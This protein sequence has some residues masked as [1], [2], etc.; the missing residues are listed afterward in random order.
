MPAKTAQKNAAA[1]LGRKRR[2]H[3]LAIF[4]PFGGYTRP[5]RLG[6]RVPNLKPVALALLVAGV[7]VVDYVSDSVTVTDEG[8]VLL[9]REGITRV[10]AV[11]LITLI[12]VVAA[13]LARWWS[14]RWWV[15]DDMIRTTGGIAHRWKREVAF[16]RIVTVDR[17]TTLWQRIFRVS[18]LA[19]ETTAM[20]QAAP[21]ILLGYLSNRDADLLE[22]LLISKLVFDG[23][24]SEARRFQLIRL[25]RLGWRDLIVAGAMTF[26][27]GRALVALWVT[28]Q[29]LEFL[30][31]PT[32]PIVFDT[33][34]GGYGL[35]PTQLA[36]ALPLGILVILW[37]TST[38]YFVVSFARFRIGKHDAWLTVETG[39]IR[40]VRRLIRIDAIQGLEVSRSPLQRQFRSKRAMLRMRMP[41]YGAPPNYAMVLHPAITD[42]ALPALT[43]QI[44]GMDPATSGAMCGRGI[45]RLSTGC[46]GAWIAYWPMHIAAVS[47][48][49]LILLLILQPDRWWWALTPMVLA[50]PLAYSGLLGWRSA[51]WYV[52]DDWLV[53]QRGAFRL[54]STAAHADRVQYLAWSKLLVSR[55]TP[56]T[57]MAISVA[58]SGGADFIS[59]IL[60]VFRR[61]VNPSI[62]RLRAVDATDARKIA[63]ESGYERSLPEWAV[64]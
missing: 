25:D 13:L 18:G 30:D 33:E 43:E 22:D 54:T 29:L 3:P 49:L 64:E 56:V 38:A 9:Q 51:G 31:M 35:S 7:L 19:I 5:P 2:L 32:P 47:G 41:A 6:W 8:E 44:I 17:S 61:P 24:E 63:S 60:A 12:G 52:G 11:I 48:A 14:F 15:E 21:D 40:S 37:V 50:V 42:A 26:Q 20:N 27:I 23:D 55:S 57:S 53:I 1:T 39:V 4:N 58:T 34:T 10:D 46:R 16:D 28:G 45:Q 59:R 62:V 36:I